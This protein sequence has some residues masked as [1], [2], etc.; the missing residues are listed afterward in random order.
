MS[1]NFFNEVAGGVEKVQAG[2]L[3]PTYDYPAKIRNPS[4][5]NMSGSGSL[6]A[7]ARDVNGLIQYMR[8]LVEG[9]GQATKTGKPLGGKF[10]L[11]TGGK[12]KGPDGN[13]Y[14][15]YIYVNNVPMGNIPVVS[16]VA[17]SNISVFQGLIPGTIENTGK[18]NPLAIFSGFM[19]KT[20][21]KCRK[22]SLPADG[23]PSSG[24]VADSDIADLDPCLWK[25][26]GKGGGNPVTKKPGR[27][28]ADSAFRNMN[29]IING[30]K[31]TPSEFKL[32]KNPL[33][34]LYNLGFGALLIYLF[35]HLMKK[36]N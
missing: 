8:V 23:S 29:N 36:G 3:G 18:I 1:G 19:Q 32:K 7:L 20:N 12:C 15:R 24:Y 31:L 21:P 10:Y 34:N 26:Y 11:K 16:S 2:F 22:L 28:C 27:G 4:E 35:F 14:D 5:L 33:A 13:T 6:S 25:V 17:G 30:S 9:R